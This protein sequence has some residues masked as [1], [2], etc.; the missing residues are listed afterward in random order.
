MRCDRCPL[1]DPEDVCPEAEGEYGIEHKDGALGCR[2]P[3]NWVKKRDDD[4]CECLGNMGTDMGVEMVLCKDFE[5]AVKLC[6]HMIGF[7]HSKPYK[8]HG[9]LFYKP[10][11][12]YFEAPPKGEPILEKLPTF[13]IQKETRVKGVWY[14]LTKQGIE[15]LGRQ[16]NVTIKEED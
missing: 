15:W 10:Y 1:S 5:K 3:R 13:I 4:Y 12:N 16:I 11:R 8:R 7:D 6:K 14:T 2:H 9:K